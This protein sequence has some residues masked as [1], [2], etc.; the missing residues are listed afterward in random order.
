MVD[1]VIGALTDAHDREEF[2]CDNEFID[3][4][5]R[6]TCHKEHAAYK[7]RVFAGTD[8]GH[9]KVLG[10]YSLTIRS[11]QPKVIKN[12]GYG[13]RD[14]PAVYFATLGVTNEAKGKGVGSALMYDSFKRTL[15]ISEHVGVYCLWLTAVDA[16]T[17]KFY[18]KL[19][20]EYIDPDTKDNLDMY[21]PRAA[22][23]DAV[24]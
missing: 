4:W 23:A 5:C 24:A 12:I 20:F 18:E 11:L 15:E 2:C 19:G 10:L 6:K 17:C 7:A 8:N 9:S 13:R 3:N 1:L 22:I 21:I 14:I 16:E